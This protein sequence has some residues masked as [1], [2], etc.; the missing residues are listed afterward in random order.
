MKKR[1]ISGKSLFA[2]VGNGAYQKTAN[3]LCDGKIIV[4]DFARKFD[5]KTPNGHT[6]RWNGRDAMSVWKQVK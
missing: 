1:K 6:V 3:Y 2:G 4:I 5:V